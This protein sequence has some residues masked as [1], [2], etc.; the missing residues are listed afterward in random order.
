M[1]GLL[2]GRY[3]LSVEEAPSC[4]PGER[5]AERIARQA[6]GKCRWVLPAATHPA[7]MVITISR[8]G[9]VSALSAM[10]LV[11]AA[12]AWP[13]CRA[14]SPERRRACPDPVFA[15]RGHQ[16]GPGA[17]QHRVRPAG[18]AAAFVMSSRG[19]A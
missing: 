14:M 15:Q 9:I 3:L 7:T 18:A 6:V 19:A 17:D 12:A 16:V 11:N 10:Q 8:R 2:A 1:E 13:E 5:M 4:S